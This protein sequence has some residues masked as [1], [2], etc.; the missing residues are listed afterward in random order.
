[1][2]TMSVNNALSRLNEELERQLDLFGDGPDAVPVDIHLHV[3]I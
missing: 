1:M 3:F 2:L